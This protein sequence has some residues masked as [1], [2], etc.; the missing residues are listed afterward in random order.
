[1]TDNLLMIMAA[2]LLITVTVM[3]LVCVDKRHEEY[4]G[5]EIR[6]VGSDAFV[7]KEIE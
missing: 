3:S 1:M 5:L 2:L 6:D 4:S 7:R